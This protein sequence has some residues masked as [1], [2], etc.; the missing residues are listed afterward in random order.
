MRPLHGA[1]DCVKKVVRARSGGLS[2]SFATGDDLVR[3]SRM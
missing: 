2:S 1:P 3:G